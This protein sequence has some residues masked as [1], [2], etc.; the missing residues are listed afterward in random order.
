MAM[1]KLKII[2]AAMA[3][4]STAGAVADWQWSRLPGKDKG[5]NIPQIERKIAEFNSFQQLLEEWQPVS[6]IGADVCSP[7]I[8]ELQVLDTLPAGDQKVFPNKGQTLVYSVSSNRGH[9][10]RL[11]DERPT[12]RSTTI[13]VIDADTKEIV[14]SN[15]L[16]IYLNGAIHD[17]IMSPDGRYLFAAGPAHTD[18]QA[19]RAGD[20][21][22]MAQM[23]AFA[24]QTDL[25]GDFYGLIGNI[26]QSTMIKIDAMTLEAVALIKFPGTVHHGSGLGRNYKNP[27]LLWI[28]VFQQDPGGAGVTIFDPDTLKVECAIPYEA[29]GKAQFFTQVHATPVTS[30]YMMLQVTPVEPYVSA[31]SVTMGDPLYLPPNFVVVVDL[32]NFTLQREIPTPPQ[33]G[34]FTITDNREQFLYNVSGGTD[35]LFK[36]D[37]NT[38]ELI[39]SARVGM[40][41]Y[42]IALNRDNTEVWVADKGES[43][44]YWGNSLTIIDNET[45]KIKSRVQLP[46]YGVDHNVLSPDGKEIW[47]TSNASGQ[48]YVV[49]IETKKVTHTITNH[50]RGS[51]HGVVFVRFDDGVTPKVMQDSHD[52]IDRTPHLSKPFRTYRVKAVMTSGSEAAKTVSDPVEAGKILFQAVDGCQICHGKEG[53]GLVGPSVRGKGYESIKA[54]IEGRRDMANWQTA[55]KLT[56]KE[57]QWIGSWLEKQQP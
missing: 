11:P 25:S 40:G 18:Y 42:G 15:E 41:P 19:M 23:S 29:I 27:N 32:N 4:L 53:E 38:G 17:T 50:G 9:V 35:Q 56:D 21:E 57:L 26:G 45:G 33:I 6:N 20:E 49:D 31:A 43:V 3:A 10:S 48:T 2:V 22:K 36:Q 28:D 5:R 24:Q 55:R 34:G 1:K 39:W 44:D 47:A 13:T 37:F 52:Y 16:P 7:D 30:D 12:A 54:A 14:A 46:G 8:K 51:T